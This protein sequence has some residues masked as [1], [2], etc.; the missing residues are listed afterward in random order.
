MKNNKK[1]TVKLLGTAFA[2][3]RRYTLL[4]IFLYVIQG[5]LPAVLT[6][7]EAEFLN[8]VLS[9]LSSDGSFS[10][11][12]CKG[13]MILLLI[14]VQWESGAVQQFVS[15]LLLS[16]MKV[17]INERIYDKKAKIDYK[18]FEND[19]ICNLIYQVSEEPE[20]KL[21]NALKNRMM[22]V[23]DIITVISYLMILLPVLSLKIW[24]LL[25]LVFPL[26]GMSVKSGQKSYQLNRELLFEKRKADYLFEILNGKE[27]AN[28]RQIFRYSKN[29]NDRNYTINETIRHHE[30]KMKLK[31]FLRL[32]SSAIL[33]AGLTCVLCV[34]M[35]YRVVSKRL[36]LGMFIS[37]FQALNSLISKLT[38][39]ITELTDK[40]AKDKGFILDLNRFFQITESNGYEQDTYEFD[41][42][43]FKE[44]ELKNVSFMYPNAD[45]YVLKDFSFRFEKGKKYSLVGV[46]GSGKS[47]LIKL[48]LGLYDEYTGTIL[49]NGHDIRELKRENLHEVFSV[50]FQD[51]ARYQLSIEEI[52]SLVDPKLLCKR[53]YIY[54]ETDFIKFVQSLPEGEQTKLGK[55]YDTNVDL[56][57]G[58]WQKLSVVK[59]LIKQ[60]AIY[61][62]DEPTA[63]LDPISELKLYEQYR[64]LKENDTLILISHRL[65][66]TKNADVIIL[67]NEGMLVAAGSHEEVYNTCPLY[68]EMFNLQKE[69]YAYEHC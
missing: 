4:Y 55:I 38:W 47:T 43:D 34:D 5:V 30:K 66:I 54:E 64:K 58:Q 44:L 2:S 25:L 19:D 27:A 8:K 12:L 35:F 29:I 11:I 31:W 51:F 61:I 50:V 9:L 18:N 14:S 49:I 6:L 63:S 68:Q 21:I 36:S 10:Y 52:M 16:K 20:K 37:M 32:K 48:L 65:G 33:I 26:L 62:L 22:L 42:R 60:A 24:I 39:Q 59:S 40:M 15:N 41:W 1:R 17:F 67:L 7:L 56:S 45:H 13:T 57:G 69:W 3:S 28:E 53:E 46:N 23:S